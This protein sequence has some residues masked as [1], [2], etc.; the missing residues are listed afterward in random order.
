M[1]KTQRNLDIDPEVKAFILEHKGDLR[2]CT[3][4][5]GPVIVPVEMKG[6]KDSDI[7]MQIGPNKLYI[8]KVQAHY[9]R[10]IEKHM[11][12]YYERYMEKKNL[13]K[14]N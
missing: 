7:V 10:R 9:L 5:G 1:E 8:S 3:T 2:L 6:P 12:A 11:L 13:E 14:K 4:C